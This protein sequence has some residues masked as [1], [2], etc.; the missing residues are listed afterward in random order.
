MTESNTE[1]DPE[2]WLKEH[3]DYLFR[4]ALFRLKDHHLAE[5]LV[6]ETLIAA[7]SAK[8][9]FKGTSSVRTWLVG[10]M[11]HKV[12]DQIRKLAKEKSGKDAE[13][14]VDFRDKSDGAHAGAALEYNPSAWDVDPG[15]LLEQREFRAQ[16]ETCVSK[17]S[18]K[19]LQVYTMREID[20]MSTEE[21][22]KAQGISSTNLWVL[23]HRARHQL[24]ECLERNWFGKGEKGS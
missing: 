19:Y 13:D 15:I 6:Q 3:G 10:I 2:F 7:I 8:D 20:G 12:V 17:L 22:C 1:L 9:R 16:F 24:R 23:L 4:Y 5:D 21:V 18:D 11:N 14:L